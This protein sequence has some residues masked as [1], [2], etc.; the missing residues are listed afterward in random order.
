MFICNKLDS[1][2]V[3]INSDMDSPPMIPV[4]T[5]RNNLLTPLF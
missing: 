4:A 2:R 1:I 5:F 3:D